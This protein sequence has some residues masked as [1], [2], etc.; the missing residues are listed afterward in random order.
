MKQALKAKAKAN[1]R[2]LTAE[3]LSVLEREAEELPPL[4]G[5]ELAR[6][7]REA[8]KLMTEKEH[9]EFAEDIERGIELM[10]SRER[11]PEP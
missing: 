2:S 1:R 5:A 7:L 11:P 4:R 10:R 6:H 9:R 3:V 8:R